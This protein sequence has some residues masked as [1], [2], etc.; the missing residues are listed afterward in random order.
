LLYAIKKEVLIKISKFQIS[1]VSIEIVNIGS[2]Y[3]LDLIL[4]S[5]KRECD[6]TKEMNK[7][8][9]RNIAD[10]KV[11]T[12]TTVMDLK[13]YDFSK[14]SEDSKPIETKC[15]R[16]SCGH[17]VGQELLKEYIYDLKFK[18]HMCNRQATMENYFETSVYEVP[19]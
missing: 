17:F 13:T 18:C 11:H 1:R 15:L 14:P 16:L 3:P 5:L 2:T 6:S 8:I 7:R 4:E 10:D 9:V 19:F 12:F